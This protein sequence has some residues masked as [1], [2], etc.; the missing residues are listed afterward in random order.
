MLNKEQSSMAERC[1]PFYDEYFD[2]DSNNGK[3]NEIMNAYDKISYVAE[4]TCFTS[5]FQD[6]NTEKS[7]KD[8]Y[9]E[10]LSMKNTFSG[11]V[12]LD[13]YGEMPYV[14]LVVETKKFN[15]AKVLE[16][17]EN[18]GYGNIV[19]STYMARFIEP[20]WVDE[21]EETDMD[22]NIMDYYIAR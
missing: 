12:S 16:Y 2:T 9:F 22:N 15:V 20:M 21:W 1:M 7:W 8:A 3:E 14:Q 10:L 4:V 11:V 5:N 19:K 18:L 6:F 17:M 13:L